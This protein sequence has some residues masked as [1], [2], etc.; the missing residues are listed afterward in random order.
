MPNGEAP[1]REEDQGQAEPQEKTQGETPNETIDRLSSDLNEMQARLDAR[2][3]VVDQAVADQRDRLW[4]AL[5]GWLE[6]HLRQ[7]FLAQTG[8]FCVECDW[9][10]KVL[11]KE[12]KLG[13]AVSPLPGDDDYG[14]AEEAPG[15]AGGDE[16]D[17]AALLRED[18]GAGQPTAPVSP[19]PGPSRQA[20]SGPEIASSGGQGP[21]R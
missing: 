16:P 17:S 14:K 12:K 13:R 21:R 10:V 7:C 18:E 2:E 5:L 1:E 19:R 4:H 15:P 11:A 8:G 20:G 3:I 9:V 6:K